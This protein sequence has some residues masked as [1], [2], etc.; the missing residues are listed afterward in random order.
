[1]QG[2]VVNVLVYVYYRLPIVHIGAKMRT[3]ININDE[4]IAEAMALTGAKTKKQAVEEALKEVVQRR[5]TANAILALRGKVDW[6]GDLDVMRRD[7]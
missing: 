3:N 6:V 7:K 5:K 4:L 2:D 1:M